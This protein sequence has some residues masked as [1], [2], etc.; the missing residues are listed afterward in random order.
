MTFQAP[1]M[2]DNA[3]FT[4][5]QRAWL[6]GY[7]AGAL[8]TL[9]AGAP[10][11]AAAAPAPPSPPPAADEALPWHD[12][13]LTLDER[14]ALAEGRPRADRLMAAMAQLDCGQ[15]GYLCRT[16]SQ[17]L[18][19]GR[20]TSIS[21]CVPGAKETQRK[22][23]E[24]LS[25]SVEAM[26]KIA[27]AIVAPAPSA[28]GRGVEVSATLMAARPLNGAGSEKDT[29]HVVFRLG[30]GRLGYEAGDSL[31]VRARNCPEVVDAVIERLGEPAGVEVDCPDG[32]RRCLRDALLVACDIG[33]PS[34]AAIEVLASR[35]RT[36]QEADRLQALAEGYPGAEPQDA[37]LLD[38][39]LAFPSARPPLQELISALGILQPRLY[40][41]ASSPKLR[42]GEVHLTVAAVRYERRGRRRKGIASTYLAER[43]SAGGE[44]PVFVQAGHG[45]R[46]PSDAATPII[47]IGPGTGVAPFRAFLQDRRA[48]GARGR[49]WLFFGDQRRSSDFLYG[50]ELES[51]RDDGLLTR[52]DVAFSRDQADKVYV[53]QR[54][55]ENAADLWAWLQEGA[56]LYVCGDASRM[57][58]DVDQALAYIISKQGG[59]DAGAAKR[60]LNELAKSGRYLRD[61]Y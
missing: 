13:A 10:A 42:T 55:R 40:S 5:A 54:M 4:P 17:A 39:L 61:V 52:L 47:M 25:E 29:R 18:D 21:L 16:Y 28:P 56:V 8:G 57:A 34:D 41:I 53:Q 60:H 59:M 7:I 3:P 26:P 31:G 50:D 6:N 48:S 19:R 43:L 37:D 46:L 36:P 58:R 15:C 33:R 45:F 44:A 27:P 9:N 22:L 20:E 1:I 49:N 12:P 23:K 24:L 35:A 51:W 32:T 14:M 38:L 2:P 11:A 30:D